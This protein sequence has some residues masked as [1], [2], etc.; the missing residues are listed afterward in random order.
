[1]LAVEDVGAVLTRTSLIGNRR[2]QVAES[3]EGTPFWKLVSDSRYSVVRTF[4]VIWRESRE[5]ER[6]D[7]VL[8][9]VFVGTVGQ[10]L[11]ID[12]RARGSVAAATSTQGTIVSAGSPVDVVVVSLFETRLM[13]LQIWEYKSV[14][15][16]AGAPAGG[17]GFDG[18]D[19]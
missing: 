8:V 3:L 19:G 18:R 14:R 7:Q 16:R 11:V 5:I 1:M 6:V 15:N 4:M 9:W 17:C 2:P 13:M 12:T 10:T